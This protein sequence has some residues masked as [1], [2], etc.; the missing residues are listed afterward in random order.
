MVTSLSAACS[1]VAHE[2]EGLHAIFDFVVTL[3]ALCY[4]YCKVSLC[5]C[6][7]MRCNKMTF[8]S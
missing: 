3:K 4:K 2:E 5:N 8:V 6:W 7:M 1:P